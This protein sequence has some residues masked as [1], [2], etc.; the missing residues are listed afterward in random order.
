MRRL[1]LYALNTILKVL[2]N[3]VS[4]ADVLRES[5]GKL[6]VGGKMVSDSDRLSLISGAKSI[7]VSI[8]WKQLITDMKYLSNKRMYE[9]SQTVDDLVFGKAMLHTLEVM[10]MKLKNL[11]NKK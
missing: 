11:S 9:N 8:T 3:T 2:Y 1:K 10:E 5:G 7:R 4:E 6:Y